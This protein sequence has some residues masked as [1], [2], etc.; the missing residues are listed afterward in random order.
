[1]VAI[2]Q[3][4]DKNMCYGFG[5]LRLTHVK[6]NY[7]YARKKKI[8]QGKEPQQFF[9]SSLRCQGLNLS[10]FGQFTA[11]KHESMKDVGKC[12]LAKGAYWQRL[13]NTSET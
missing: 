8:Q 6:G 13:P 11:V 12:M 2:R 9:G 5:R 10:G 3:T 4:P 7:N 1:M